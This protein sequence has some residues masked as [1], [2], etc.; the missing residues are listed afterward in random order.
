M[1]KKK[2]ANKQPM[3]TAPTIRVNRVDDIR[4]AIEKA[5]DGSTIIL[6]SPEHLRISEHLQRS[7]CPTKA[8]FFQARNPFQMQSPFEVGDEF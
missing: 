6:F 3:A 4:E 2:G 7:V 8:L 1:T 5:Q